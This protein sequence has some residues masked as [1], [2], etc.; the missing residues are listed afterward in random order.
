MC[1]LWLK[2]FT[3]EEEEGSSNFYS[4]IRVLSTLL[5]II[6]Y[7]EYYRMNY[8]FSPRIKS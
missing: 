2:L 3:A 4:F 6:H 1:F 7:H 8:K 5:L